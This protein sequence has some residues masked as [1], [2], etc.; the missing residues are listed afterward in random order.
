MQ[1]HF[2]RHRQRCAKC[3]KSLGEA[4]FEETLKKRRS[5]WSD[6]GRSSESSQRGTS[7]Q[8][9]FREDGRLDEDDD[10]DA[11]GQ[12]NVQHWEQRDW[13][14]NGSQDWWGNQ[15]WRSSYYE[16][17]NSWDTSNEI[18]IPEFLAGFLLLHRSGLEPNQKSGILGGTTSVARAL[19]EQ[20][21]DAD[22]AKID[23]QKASAMMADEMDDEEAY[24]QEEDSSDIGALPEDVQAAYHAE[25]ARIDNAL[26][27]I[28]INK[29]TLKEARWNQKQMKLNRNFFPK[30]PFQKGQAPRPGVKCFKCGG[31]HFQ[32]QCPQRT[33]KDAKVVVEAAEIAFGASEIAEPKTDP[34]Q[35]ACSSSEMSL[36]TTQA[37][38]QCMGIIDSGATASLGSIDA[39][40]SIVKKNIA[41]KGDS[42][43]ELDLEKRPTFKFGNG[44]TKT[45][46]ST[47]QLKVDA[48]NHR[49]NME[50]HVHDTPQQPILVSRKALRSLGAVIDFERNQVI[51][52]HV[53]PKMVVNLMEAEN[54]H[55]LM[56]LT[57]NLT[58][59]GVPRE[60]ALQSLSDE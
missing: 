8:G 18:F 4:T 60:T 13:D 14:W 2:G 17:P 31:P 22:L 38:E 37:M 52:R 5:A 10:E 29:T 6:W 23:R 50:V 21:S 20:W 40:E 9:P 43:I 56:P 51:Y 35:M 19:R 32:D 7:N 16:P 54:G 12:D 46:V 47:A 33:Q 48:G 24:Y 59:G 26:E 25:Q 53:D 28:R 57:G 41:Q 42:R 55:L 11:D 1:K 15:S 36:V 45:C 44:L 3:K 49:G 39:M 27:A 58:A 30:K 34:V